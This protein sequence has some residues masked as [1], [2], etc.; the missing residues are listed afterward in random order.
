VD[1]SIST[2]RE[3]APTVQTLNIWTIIIPALI[4][5]I[6]ATISIIAWYYIKNIKNRLK[7]TK[8]E[9]HQKPEEKPVELPAIKKPMARIPN[10]DRAYTVE[11]MNETR[12]LLEKIEQGFTEYVEKLRQ[13]DEQIEETYP[14]ME[15]DKIYP[16]AKKSEIKD[17]EDIESEVD[18][19][20]PEISKK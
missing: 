20:L 11:M 17:I 19:L 2:Y 12:V 4:L 5:A 14:K 1:G 16:E 9:E 3:E 10:T 18:K 15:K 13:L 8:Y 6:L 7:Y